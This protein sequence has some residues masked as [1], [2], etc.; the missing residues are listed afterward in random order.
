MK[1]EPP[2]VQEIAREDSAKRRGTQRCIGGW[3]RF[4]LVTW[5]GSMSFPSFAIL[6][7]GINSPAAGVLAS[8]GAVVGSYARL[9][10]RGGKSGLEQQILVHFTRENA[11]DCSEA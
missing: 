7:C 2:I 9:I 8:Q 4:F 5:E 1:Q 6:N 10:M 11:Q 3:G